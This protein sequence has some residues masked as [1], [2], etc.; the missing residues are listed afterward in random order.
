MGFSYQ[1]YRGY[2]S[3]FYFNDWS[4]IS[5]STPGGTPLVDSY[6]ILISDANNDSVVSDGTCSFSL[7]QVTGAYSFSGLPDGSTRSGTASYTPPSGGFPGVWF[8]TGTSGDYSYNCLW[9]EKVSGTHTGTI[10]YNVIWS[11]ISAVT[12]GLGDYPS[13]INFGCSISGT[14]MI[15]AHIG[16][17]PVFPKPLRPIFAGSVWFDTERVNGSSGFTRTYSDGSTKSYVVATAQSYEGLLNWS[18]HSFFDWA[19]PVYRRHPGRDQG[20]YVT[21]TFS[22]SAIIRPRTGQTPET[23]SVDKIP[24]HTSNTP[25][26]M[27]TVLSAANDAMRTAVQDAINAKPHIRSASFSASSVSYNENRF[28]AVQTD[29]PEGLLCGVIVKG[30]TKYYIWRKTEEIRSGY[31]YDRSQVQYEMESGGTLD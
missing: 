16:R 4:N 12:P 27:E 24:W 11:T 9:R 14:V 15:G 23:I 5:K 26:G 31:D 17:A 21:Q 13:K 8:I 7:D 3:G 10:P 22:T 1:T 28:W 30:A 6:S 19:I 25:P 20:A 18:G 29:A 2:D